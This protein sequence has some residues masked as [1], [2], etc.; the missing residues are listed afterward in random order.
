MGGIA[1]DGPGSVGGHGGINGGCAGR[2]VWLNAWKYSSSHRVRS[3][4]VDTIGCTPVIG[5][6]F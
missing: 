2:G 6:G 5:R 3:S 1:H 4:M